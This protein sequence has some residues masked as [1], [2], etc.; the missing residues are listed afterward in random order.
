MNLNG[1]TKKQVAEKTKQGR[2]NHTSKKNRNTIP[3]IILKNSL[4]IFNFVNLTLALMIISV[5]SYKN[6]LFVVIAIANT[7]ISIER[8]P[9]EKNH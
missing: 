4:T 8:N 5:H 3:K 2:I 9:R 7:L 6:L 1:L